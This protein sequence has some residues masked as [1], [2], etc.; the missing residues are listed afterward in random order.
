LVAE[1]VAALGFDRVC[2]GETPLFYAAQKGQSSICAFL[3]QNG[4]EV[5][6]KEHR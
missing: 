2:S 4:A 5:N 3:L 1:C 6:A